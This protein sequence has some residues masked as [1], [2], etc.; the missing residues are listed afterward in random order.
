MDDLS[1]NMS[2]IAKRGVAGPTDRKMKSIIK[3][4]SSL[5]ALNEDT[6]TDQSS[7][8][9]SLESIV[10]QPTPICIVYYIYTTTCLD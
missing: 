4:K 6:P 9:H 7:C 10:V 1:N 5:L 2:T 8:F 3:C